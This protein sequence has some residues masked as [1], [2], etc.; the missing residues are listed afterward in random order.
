MREKRRMC[1]T[2]VDAT[3]VCTGSQIFY[4]CKISGQYRSNADYCNLKNL[5]NHKPLPK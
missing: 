5:E 3:T 2:C 4:L 1:R